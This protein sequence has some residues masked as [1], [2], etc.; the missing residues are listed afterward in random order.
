MAAT[1]EWS[2]TPPPALHD[3]VVDESSLRRGR[4]TAN[5]LFGNAASVL[6]GR[7]PVLARFQMMVR[8]G[9]MRVLGSARRDD[10]RHRGR[11]V[12]P[13]L[14]MNMH[15]AGHLG[16]GPSASG[17]PRKTAKPLRGQRPHRR[18]A[19]S[20]AA[21]SR[22]PRAAYGQARWAPPSRSPTTC[23]TTRGTTAA[24]AE[25]R[26]RPARRQPTLPLLAAMSR[27]TPGRSAADPPCDPE[28]RGRASGR[29]RRR[30]RRTGSST[31][32]AKPPGALERAAPY[33]CSF[34]PAVL[35]RLTVLA[36]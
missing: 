6:V 9:C 26:R 2:S 19:G 34:F 23:S 17:H 7:L 10:Q 27:G 35:L 5:A 36:G 24:W 32:P 11:E 31:S 21:R 13:A 25:R 1:V 28:R 33:F 3:D 12:L 22:P 30:A 14:M 4:Q 8:R 20:D 16:R 15:D 18:G 29:D